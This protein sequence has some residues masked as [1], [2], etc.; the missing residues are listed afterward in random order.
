MKTETSTPWECPVCS[1]INACDVFRCAWCQRER[2]VRTDLREP[3]AV[4]RD[5]R[6]VTD[7]LPPRKTGEGNS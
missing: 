4:A 1:N 6:A 5:E 7:P 2:V 3:H